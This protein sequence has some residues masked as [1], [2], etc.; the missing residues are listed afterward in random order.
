MNNQSSDGFSRNTE[1]KGK[2]DSLDLNFDEIG[3]F[4]STTPI[5]SSAAINF[6]RPMTAKN[7]SDFDTGNEEHKLSSHFGRTQQTI[8]NPSKAEESF[9]STRQMKP[10]IKRR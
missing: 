2:F 10:P 5:N 9:V 4:K 6:G 1:K 3:K 8:I 7:Y